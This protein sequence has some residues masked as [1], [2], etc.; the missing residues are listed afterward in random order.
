MSNADRVKGSE[1]QWLVFLFFYLFSFRQ[2]F[3]FSIFENFSKQCESTV[4]KADNETL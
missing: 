3:S 4:R 1:A 2:N